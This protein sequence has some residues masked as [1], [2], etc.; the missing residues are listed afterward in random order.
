LAV[1][2]DESIKFERNVHPIFFAAARSVDDELF[3]CAGD[4]VAH[5]DRVSSHSTGK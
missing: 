1:G 5:S 3:A 2:D 4:D